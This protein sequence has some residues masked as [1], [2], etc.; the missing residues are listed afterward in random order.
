MSVSVELSTG[1]PSTLGTRHRDVRPYFWLVSAAWFALL[2]WGVLTQ[3]TALADDWPRL[4]PWI[5]LLAFVNL[6]PL[7]GWQSAHMVPDVPIAGAASMILSPLEAGLVG[8]VSAFD[9]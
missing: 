4:L 2:G 5:G 1:A 9:C 7:D 3:G 6:L 8:F